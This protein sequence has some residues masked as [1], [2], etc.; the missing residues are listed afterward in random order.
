MA[1]HIKQLLKNKRVKQIAV[2]N[3]AVPEIGLHFTT[4]LTVSEGQELA[5]KL[6][7]IREEGTKIHTISIPNQG[8][9]SVNST[10]E[11]ATFRRCDEYWDKCK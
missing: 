7:D 8:L 6:S 4:T 2:Y 11:G 3:V 1:K 10:D 9:I 5:M